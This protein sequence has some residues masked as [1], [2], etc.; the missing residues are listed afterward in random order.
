MPPR[1]TVFIPTYNRARFLSGAIESVLAQTYDDFRLEVSD[2]A[3]TDETP[4]VVK[5]FQD[6]RLVY[7]RQPENIGLLGNHNQFLKSVDTEYALILP[8]DD[9]VGPR[10]LEE[11]VAALDAH[12][13]AGVAHAEFELLDEAGERLSARQNWTY[14]L[15]EDTV[16]SAHQ[17]IR[18]SMKWSCRICASTALM[19]TT[20]LPSDGMRATDFPAVDFG[21]WLRMAGGG[22]DFAFLARPLGAY[23]IHS[24]SHSAAFGPATGPGYVQGIEIVSTLYGVKRRFLEQY[25]P[26]ERR[27]AELTRLAQASLRRE[28][29]LMVRNLTLPE[30]RPSRTLRLLG[31]AVRAEPGVVREPSA[32]R[33]MVASLVGPRVVE[34]ARSLTR[35][36]GAA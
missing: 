24:A 26:D 18:E 31:D 15:S 17:F 36:K 25:E 30:R 22:W 21:M 13:R 1:V 34:R 8:D 35:A 23:R 16:E 32:W 5:R 19:R 28:L 2:N 7:R 3:S 10:L 6:P 4:E 33:L 14:G 27:R 9:L 20:A 11:T 12:P 29:V